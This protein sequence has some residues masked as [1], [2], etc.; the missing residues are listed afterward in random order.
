MN[1]QHERG[2]QPLGGQQQQQANN[3]QQPNVINNLV[4]DQNIPNYVVVNPNHI[5]VRIKVTEPLAIVDEYS[6]YNLPL[7]SWI[8][9]IQ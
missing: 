1:P 4:N 8:L 5:P 9:Q 3:V 2:I 6:G 7:N